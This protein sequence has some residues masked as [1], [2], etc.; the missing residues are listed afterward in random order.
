MRPG[1]PRG[2][3]WGVWGDADR[4]GCLNL[5]N[6]GRT[7]EAAGLVRKG[8]V[9]AM[10]WDMGLPDPPLFGRAAFEHQVHWL[11]NEVGHDDELSGWNTQSSS[12]WDGFRH[13]R[14]AAYGFYGGVP[15][16]DHGIHHW[17]E[18]GLAGRAV[19]LD[20][21]RWR[22]SDGRPL[23]CDQPDPIE[24]E[25]LAATARAQGVEVREGDVLLIRTG[26]I[27][28]YGGLGAEQ[29]KALATDLKTPGLRPGDATA[30]MLW[31]MHVAAVAGD[32]PALEVWPPGSLATPE[33][34]QQALGD[35]DRALEIFVHFS[36]LPLLG[37]P[38]GEMWYL[39]ALAED[40]ASD[41]VYEGFFT[42][43]P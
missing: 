43:A 25:D 41:G 15:D 27:S 8:S 20:V 34:L 17:A 18:R 30:R 19:L 1:A 21:A 11:Q 37:L 31:D 5:L 10:N 26:W 32:N 22:E 2:S 38:I 36:L 16:E 40:C 6:T 14:S 39:D 42:S 35:P 28:W 13:I 4:L 24:P 3:S 33:Q 7:V 29:R 12:Q 9:F 23:H